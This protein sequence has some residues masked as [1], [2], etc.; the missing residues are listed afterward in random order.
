MSIRRQ[1]F[2]FAKV[3]VVLFALTC[4]LAF[5][6]SADTLEFQGYTIS[7][8]NATVSRPDGEDGDVV[9][10]FDADGSFTLPDS[11]PLANV[12]IL[13]VGGGGAGGSGASYANSTGKKYNGGGGGGGG[14]GVVD[15]TVYV[16]AGKYVV[17]VGS[18]GAVAT[19]GASAVSGNSG[20]P[21]SV[22]AEGEDDALVK[23][24]GGGGGGAQTAGADGA[25]GGGGSRA[26]S[27]GRSVTKAGGAGT[28][29]QGS[30]G[31]SGNATYIGGGGGGAGA[32]GAAASA[33]GAGGA[34]KASDITGT[35]VDY[36]GGGGGGRLSTGAAIG[37]GSG[38]GGAGGV[39]T[40][41][42]AKDGTDGLGGGGG[43]GGAYDASYPEYAIGGAG[44]RGVVIV[45]I[46][47][48]YAL[49]EKP[50]AECEFTY[51][52]TV[53]SALSESDTY[54]I[55]GDWKATNVGE[56]D[57]TVSLN[58]DM[59]AQGL[60][61]ADLTTDDVSVK[62]TISK[63]ANS[64]SGLALES[65]INGNLP[66]SPSCKAALGTPVYSWSDAEDGEYS[67]YST[68][69]GGYP[70]AVGKYWIKAEV[71]ETSNYDGAESVAA[72]Y[73]WASPSAAYS[74]EVTIEV[75][76][77]IE[78][79]E[80]ENFPVLV[81]L[82]ESTVHGF[83]YSRAGSTGENL[84]FT[85]EDGSVRYPH[86]VDV[87]DVT[88]ESAVWVRVSRLTPKTKIVL[89][90]CQK[91]GVQAP[92]YAP[93]AVWSEY[94]GVWHFAG[95]SN[96]SRFKDS[97]GNGLT[98]YLATGA[99]CANAANS[100]IGS[101]VVVSGGVLLVPDYST[102]LADD[103]RFSFFEWMG[104][105]GFSGNATV[106]CGK[107]GTPTASGGVSD[108]WALE[109]SDKGTATWQWTGGKLSAAVDGD[110]T[111]TAGALL[112]V[113][114]EGS[115]VGF[116][117]YAMFSSADQYERV[118]DSS[119]QVKRNGVPLRLAAGGFLVD[120]A[121]LAARP[122]SEAWMRAEYLTVCPTEDAGATYGEVTRDGMKVDWWKVEAAITKSTWRENEEAGALTA[123][124]P[125]S[126]RSVSTVYANL[127]TSE[128]YDVMPAD[129]GCYRVTYEVD[130][131]G[132]YEPLSASV[133]FQIIGLAATYDDLKGDAATLTLS[134]RVLLAN[135]DVVDGHAVTDQGYW[136]LNSVRYGGR[137]YSYTTFWV[138][139]GEHEATAG[140]LRNGYDHDLVHCENG[141]AE[142]NCLWRL[143][144]VI[145]GSPYVGA[146]ANAASLG[147]R[148]SLPF[149][150]TSRKI[151][152][153]ASRNSAATANEAGMMM[154]RNTTEAAIYSPCY[155]NGVG[156]VY[157][158][159]VNMLPNAGEGYSLVV[160]VATNTVENLPPTDENCQ[161]DGDSSGWREFGKLEGVD[162][163]RW[164]RASML[165]LKKDGTD[166]FVSEGV[167]SGV[168]LKV[169]RSGGDR[170]YRIA[171]PVDYR[172]PC[173]FRIR[174]N[175]TYGVGNVDV[176][177][178][179]VVDNV[180]V[181]P[182]KMSAN[183]VPYGVFD[184]SR[185]GGRVPGCVG[186]MDVAFPAV[187]E[188]VS[189]RARVEAL[190]NSAASDVDLSS[191]I[192]LSRLN[193]RWRYLGQQT[194]PWR[195]TLLASVGDGALKSVEPLNLPSLEGDVEFWFESYL[196]V[197]YYDY[198]DY[199]GLGLGLRD[200]DG[201]ALYLETE[202]D[203]V[204]NRYSLAANETLPSYGRDWF[205]RLRPTKSVYER[206]RVLT[207]TN[208]TAGVVATNEMS[209]ASDGTWRGFAKT[210]EAPADGLLRFRFEGLNPQ[211]DGATDYA[212]STNE[213][214]AASLASTPGEAD[215]SSGSGWATAPC[216]AATGYLMFQVV[217][218]TADS[219]GKA[220]VARADRQDFNLWSSGVTTNGLFTGSSDNTN[221]TSLV[222][223]TYEM[224]FAS[225][226]VSVATNSAWTETFDVGSGVVSR[227]A[228]P[229]NVPFSS[230]KSPNGWVAENAM[231]TYAKWADETEDG[232]GD[233]T[234]L[235][236][237][238]RGRGTFSFAD[239]SSAPNGL[240][241]VVFKARVAQYN[242]FN[243]F[244]YYNGIVVPASGGYQQAVNQTRYT[245]VTK[246]AMTGAGERSFDGDGSVSLVAAY[247]PQYGCYELR[248]S[249]S[250][251][252]SVVCAELFKWTP[253]SD[254]AVR[255]VSL[256]RSNL[257][258]GT[259]E[260]LVCDAN[261]NGVAFISFA[262]DAAGAGVKVYGGLYVENTDVGTI[263]DSVP[264]A[265]SGKEFDVVAY[266]DTDSPLTK[267]SYGFLARNCPG[268]FTSPVAYSEEVA[269]A[270]V[271]DQASMAANE[272]VGGLGKAV[273]FAGGMTALSA[274]DDWIVKSGRTER[275]YN[276]VGGF[277]GFRAATNVTQR[278]LLQLAPAG[279]ATWSDF[280]TNS[281]C[282][283]VDQVFTNHVRR[284]TTYN[285]RFKM[286][287]SD[288]GVRLDV[289]MNYVHL[290][291]W[292]GQT[293]SGY[294]S[295]TTGLPDR[296]VYLQSWVT[297]DRTVRVQP[298]RAA[299]AKSAMGLRT[300][301]MAGLGL[302]G[303]S[304]R[305]ADENAVLHLQYATRD[306]QNLMRNAMKSLTDAPSDDSGWTT[307]ETFRFADLG[308]EGTRTLALNVR[309]PKWGVFRLVCDQ[310][311]VTNACTA[312]VADENP[313]Y[314]SVEV[315]A[316]FAWDLPAYDSR[317]WTGW[318]FRTA[319]WQDY[320]AGPF[321]NLWDYP[322][323]LSGLLN[324]T[325][326]AS[327][328][329]TPVVDYYRQ[330]QPSIQ[331]PTFATNCVGAVE[332]KARLYD[333]G[334]AETAKHGAA[335]T[336]YGA[337]QVDASG[338][339]K[340]WKAVGDV[341]VTNAVYETFVMKLRN[342]ENFYALR[343]G[344]KGVEGVDGAETPVYDPPLR[345]AIDDI[346]IWEKTPLAVSFRKDRVR[347]FRNATALRGSGVV[348]DI[349]SAEEQPILAETFGFQAEVEVR[350]TNEI[351][352][353]DPTMP[354]SVTL[355][356]YPSAEPWGFDNWKTN[357]GVR[358]VTLDAADGTNLVFRS[359]MAK[360]ASLCPP[361]TLSDGETHRVV[362]YQLV[363]SFYDRSG[364]RFEQPMSS[365]EWSM[366]SW[367]D[368]FDDPNAKSGAAFSAFTVLEAIAPKRA[369]INEVNYVEGSQDESSADQWVELAIPSGVSM[370]DWTLRLYDRS[371]NRVATLLT[372]G[373]NC[374][375]SKQYAPVNRYEFYV[376]KS[377]WTTLAGADATWGRDTAYATSAISDGKLAWTN[378]FGFELVRPSGIVE[379]RVVTQG[380]NI[381]R[382]YDIAGD[383]LYDGTNLVR[384]LNEATSGG[385][386]WGEEDKKDYLGSTLGVLANQGGA[387]EDWYSPMGR[388][389]GEVNENQTIDPD[390]FTR[391]NG[392]FRWIDAVVSG[393]HLRQ[394]V[395]GETN[396]TASIS[397][398]SGKTTNFVYEVDR[399]YRLG[400]P[401][402][403]P[404]TTATTITGPVTK[405]RRSYYTI[406]FPE[407]TND[408]RVTA[409][410]EV[411][412]D[413]SAHLEG[414]GAYRP[415]ILKWLE[416][417]DGVFEGDTIKLG[418]YRGERGTD[419][420][421][422]EIGLKGLYWLDLDPTC[423][424]WELWGGMGA[425]GDATALGPVNCSVVRSHPL[426]P[427]LAPLHTNIQTTVWL[428]ITN[429][430]KAG[431]A[432]Y[433]PYRLQ[434]LGNEQSDLYAGNWT[435]ATFKVELQ[436]YKGEW[437]GRWR[438]MRYFVFG[439]NSFRPAG[440]ET[441][442]FSARIEM[443]DPFSR[444]SPAWEWEWWKY[445]DQGMSPWTRWN[446][447]EDIT[448]GGVST[449][450]SDDVLSY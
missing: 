170:F 228:M 445:A 94:L 69:V 436:L 416:E 26:T 77:L 111:Q 198:F 417:N 163:S 278:L 35:S 219:P 202:G 348:E 323:G 167:S 4:A 313:L 359:T 427:S 409:A 449:L 338:E 143:R 8:E 101:A 179:V 304:W 438:A 383:Y 43:G 289:V 332:F 260:K 137:T 32:A 279:T 243:D 186:V 136:Q 283:F 12:R 317:S 87:W 18:G 97:T 164:H 176:G 329:A 205:F 255:A 81:R 85:S 146:D 292:A 439:P 109:A 237:Q 238:G 262:P 277:V 188:A 390:W 151:S 46:S 342:S 148:C 200:E 189:G 194:G 115:G 339:P 113:V 98:A 54:T 399:W 86:E 263:Y 22:A 67:P 286:L 374:P 294:A 434:G 413:L 175:S 371:G 100:R 411:N 15:K 307:M 216:D 128:T 299:S 412:D 418:K 78:S 90:W 441:A 306:T 50:A 444:Q 396:L 334:D 230:A 124:V 370:K 385:W 447:N 127:I 41:S 256:G 17:T 328:L 232:F 311:V 82:S 380:Y 147:G 79:G 431:F 386:V 180:I 303:F 389:P 178:F 160:E 157:F 107:P 308:A 99:S 215:V 20:N 362:Q 326:D 353:D 112:G 266:Y 213:W 102:R 92:A 187:G 400:A 309:A 132:V 139:G 53:H 235:Q 91:D 443:T 280:A 265:L 419:E 274:P 64:I 295:G 2:A 31:G 408:V 55:S 333:A 352:T 437:R 184:N 402:V 177:A 210:L 120:E 259:T 201:N 211:E 126:G 169:G 218:P 428:M 61:W 377:P 224:D 379:H 287:G 250:M 49:P 221:S 152:S 319:G 394:I 298:A 302:V 276:A 407:L 330:R 220:L 29:G 133:D 426:S 369:W 125:N 420:E 135:D 231:W 314:G 327:T 138:H 358:R 225:L 190:V 288:D 300:Q 356:Y 204:T 367:N 153:Y 66:R 168:A 343:L 60:T 185:A 251:T 331:S 141:S 373:R 403:V 312:A 347:P 364:E 406:S 269:I 268:L 73:V 75:S 284:G 404:A 45:R 429:T 142:T 199:S 19:S 122:L 271:T 183:V 226:P 264:T 214:Q 384:V 291:Q 388:T 297:G 193:Y 365:G 134:G 375:E 387:H 351:V 234:A 119:Y 391:P 430:V 410:A 316:F 382:D 212:Y 44:G 158:D 162:G 398:E 58:P 270:G 80:L 144:S 267:G 192:T 246:L 261:R 156:T 123:P 233:P 361:Q 47:A 340:H 68:S 354:L 3:R 305:N 248:F 381:F 360:T 349:D 435:S 315:A 318:N 63:A 88:G 405:G 33:G 14:G 440:D 1:S 207:C 48:V 244:A 191:F 310:S 84:A 42:F 159:A 227:D 30:A 249:R 10:A 281:V 272:L 34:G 236:L 378:P 336:V 28:D 70:D 174:R 320:E 424:G 432:A 335:V 56:Y 397:V 118:S 401:T 322:T 252:N 222:T 273:T 65:W 450:K 350:D 395:G 433:P 154:L 372:F 36:G 129:P 104:A 345:V 355:W 296:F 203:M 7:Y 229:R 23:A 71:E 51:D 21:S 6:S 195:S 108:G 448:P 196:S 357:E 363:A 121:R 72:F 149:S 446:L 171:V 155:T 240:D 165:V 337:D 414:V 324:N 245:F 197:P 258:G 242:E 293:T 89:R 257:S 38:G 76:G 105:P 422:Q 344:V 114:S 182:P 37:G 24:E 368:G 366:P 376:V 239:Q 74:D 57:A 106:F 83:L 253:S 145:I 140:T 52:G 181:S 11:A 223:Q 321:A 392:G 150:S 393:L 39:V 425:K 103:A 209:L 346:V 282:G 62:M 285:I 9:L 442:P 275:R 415:A 421:M 25:S 96:A 95:Q 247:H 325:L 131:D 27:S 208:E 110:F 217:E 423:G 173:R 40:S 301:M 117:R 116:A 290:E 206:W 241:N 13:A 166:G 341:V 59:V 254:G 93:E 161:G 5:A 172:G 130:G 16:V